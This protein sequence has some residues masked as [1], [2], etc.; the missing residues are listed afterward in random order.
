MI[1][2][3]VMAFALYGWHWRQRRREHDDE[4]ATARAWVPVVISLL[5]VVAALG[6]SVQVVL[7]GHS[8]A[9]AT[10][11]DVASGSAGAGSADD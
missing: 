2:L 9:K 5:A 10:W 7:I 4:K 1:V 3:V 8:G 11:S 6:T